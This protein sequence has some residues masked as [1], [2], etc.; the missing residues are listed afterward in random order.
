M[1]KKLEGIIKHNAKVLVE[2]IREY[3]RSQQELW[4]Q[5]PNLALEADGRTGYDNNYSRAYRVGY[6]GLDSCVIDGYY[7]VHVDLAT[8]ELIDANVGLP[9]CPVISDVAY[10]PKKSQSII[11][12]D[13]KVIHLAYSLHELNAPRIIRE[14]EK[15]A[16]EPVRDY[17]INADGKDWRDKLRK[18]LQLTEKY[19]RRT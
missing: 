19:T 10:V 9:Y 3:S 14:L 1:N 16:Q 6:W 8:G 5:I 12:P 18:E 2:N 15:K 11:A 17:I 7:Q 13:N 4:Q